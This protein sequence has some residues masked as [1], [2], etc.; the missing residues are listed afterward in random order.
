MAEVKGLWEIADKVQQDAGG[1]LMPLK[2]KI[3]DGGGKERKNKALGIADLVGKIETTESPFSTGIQINDTPYVGNPKTY[4]FNPS[5]YEYINNPQ[6][7][8]ADILGSTSAYL[9][10]GWDKFKRGG[11]QF[12]ANFLSAMGQG[13]ANLFDII[14]TKDKLGA[15]LGVNDTD[16]NS[17]FLG[18]F[19]SKD[20]MEWAEGVAERN[21][22]YQER[23]GA[24]DLT[25]GGWWANQFAQLG[26]SVGMMAFSML[27]TA[28]I[29]L[30]TG[31]TGTGVAMARL[32]R[33]IKNLFTAAKD[34]KKVSKVL[35]AAKGM[36]SA[37]TVFGIT[38]RL[39]E[40]SME[41]LQVYNKLYK[42]L[43][44]YRDEDGVGLTEEEIKHAA[45][46]GAAVDYR[47]NLAL[48]PLDILAFR[49]LVFNPISGSA[50]GWV[51]RGLKDIAGVF[52]K[53]RLGKATGWLTTKTIGINIEGIEEGFQQIGQTEGEYF[54]KR[55]VNATKEKDFYD[56]VTETVKSDEFWNNYAGGVF[57]GMFLGPLSTSVRAAV[58]IKQRRQ[59]NAAYKGYV[60]TAGTLHSEYLNEINKA[61]KEGDIVKAQQLRRQA[62]VQDFV[63]RRHL[64]NRLERT[65][66]FNSKLTFLEGVLEELNNGKTTALEDMGFFGINEKTTPEQL[67][68]I[69]ENFKTYIEDGKEVAQIYDNLKTT[70]DRAF[71]PDV[72]LANFFLKK[73]P[74]QK[75]EILAKL[76]E[77]RNNLTHYSGLSERGKRIHDIG[78][79][80]KSLQ[81]SHKRLLEILE[82]T[83][84]KKQKE[85]VRTVI[86]ANEKKID[87]QNTL[88]KSIQEDEGYD[89]ATKEA[90]N[91]I[92]TIINNN[93]NKD[94]LQTVYDKV[95]LEDQTSLATKNLTLW[96][97]EEYLNRRRE[98]AI[99]K[100]KDKEEVE[101][102]QENKGKRPETLISKVKNKANSLKKQSSTEASL[103]AQAEAKVKELDAQAGKTA[104]S[105]LAEKARLAR[106]S[107][108]SVEEADSSI[109]AILKEVNT[110]TPGNSTFN[111][112]NGEGLNLDSIPNPDELLSPELSDGEN[113]SESRESKII[114]EVGKLLNILGEDA[115]Y[116]ELLREFYK[117][118][119]IDNSEE[120]ARVLA[121]GY[122]GNKKQLSKEAEENAIS[123]VL[124]GYIT[125]LYTANS[126]I[127]EGTSS[128]KKAVQLQGAD[129]TG[130]SATSTHLGIPPMET[131]EGKVTFVYSGP[132]THEHLPKGAFSTRAVVRT[133]IEGEDNTIILETEYANEVGDSNNEFINSDILLDPDKTDSG[134]LTEIRI[135]ENVDNVTVSIYGEDG[136]FLTAMPFG[137]WVGKRAGE[138]GITIENFKNTQEYADKVP[139]IHYLKDGG[140]NGK[141]IM[142]VADIGWYHPERFDQNR[143]EERQLAIENTRR[144]RKEVI[145]SA[146][147]KVD[148]MIISKR[149]TTF[150]P[151]ILSKDAPLITLQEANPQTILAVYKEG[152]G[153]ESAPNIPAI[154]PEEGTIIGRK[155]VPIKNGAIVELRR[156]G[157]KDGKP[158]FVVLP[159]TREKI[160]TTA[161]KSVY[162]AIDIF[163]N[164]NPNNAAHV[165]AVNHIKT[166]MGLDITRIEGLSGYLKHFIHIALDDRGTKKEDVAEIMK[167]KLVHGTPY[168]AIAGGSVV[169]GRVGIPIY[170]TTDSSGKSV[171]VE[172]IF[173]TPSPKNGAVNTRARRFLT[174]S[175]S[176][177]APDENNNL[178][179]ITYKTI[180][181]WFEPSMEL[182]TYAKNKPVV[183]ITELSGFTTTQVAGSLREYLLSKLLTNVKS[184]NIGTEDAPNY[185]TNA[186][187]IVLYD[188]LSH[189]NKT[190][191]QSDVNTQQKTETEETAA[192]KNEVV[193]LTEEEKNL[194][195]E[196]EEH[197]GEDL[198]KY[199]DDG[200]YSPEILSD[201]Q[202]RYISNN[203]LG[204]IGGLDPDEAEVIINL[205]YQNILIREDFTQKGNKETITREVKEKVLSTINA[206]LEKDTA[207]LEKIKLLQDKLNSV[208]EKYDKITKVLHTLEHRI[209]KLNSIK[210]N[211][212]MFQTRALERAEKSI[213]VTLDNTEITIDDIDTIESI[214][215]NDGEVATDFFTDSLTESPEKRV[216]QEMRKLFSGIYAY[217]KNGN[218]VT[219]LGIEEFVNEEDILR[220]V[221]RLLAN[222]ESSFEV[223]INELKKYTEKYSWMQAIIN[224][225][226]Q[227][228][229]SQKLKN[230]FLAATSYNSLSM[231]HSILSYNHKTKKWTSRV[232]DSVANSTAIQI[233]RSWENNLFEDSDYKMFFV[234]EDGEQYVNKALVNRLIHVFD[235][236]TGK[237]I[238][239]LML[240]MNMHKRLVSNLREGDLAAFTPPNNVVK[241]ELEKMLTEATQEVQFGISGRQYII[242][243]EPYG[244]TVRLKG[245][246]NN[247][248][249][250]EEVKAWLKE[251]GIEVED[252]TIETLLTDGLFHGN[253]IV[254]PEGLT[255]KY[256]ILGIL[257]SKLKTLSGIGESEA[258]NI[259]D[260]EDLNPLRQN[261]I[262]S[263][264]TLDARYNTTEIP[265]ST[266]IKG[267]N[268]FGLIQNKFVVDREKE[269][270]K[271]HSK[272]RQELERAGFSRHS[273]WLKL[274]RSRIFRDGVFAIAHDGLDT[275]Q[276]NG[277]TTFRD[278]AGITNLPKKDREIAKLTKF[279]A[280]DRSTVQNEQGISEEEGIKL[281][282]ARMAGLTNADKDIMMDVR[283][284]V[285]SLTEEDLQG[286]MSDRLVKII[287]EQTVL[288][289]IQRMIDTTLA[290]EL[291]QNVNI[292]GYNKGVFV[293]NI[294]PEMNFLSVESGKTLAEAIQSNPQ[295]YNANIMLQDEG[296]RLKI[297]KTIRDTIKSL[298]S[299]KLN[300][301]KEIGIGEKDSK[302]GV[303][304]II[305]GAYFAGLSGNNISHED[306]LKYAAMDYE[307]NSLI[308]NANYMMMFTGD[309][310]MFYK[311]GVDEVESTFFNINKRNSGTIAPMS[312]LSNTTEDEQYI[313]LFI[314]DAKVTN[315]DTVDYI[316]EL[317]GEIGAEAFSEI[318]GTDSQEVTTWKEHLDNLSRLGKLQDTLMDITTE[319]IEI[320]REMLSKGTRLQDLT[321]K[322][323][324]ILTK[325]ANPLKPRYYGQIYDPNLNVMRVVYI[326]SS[327][328][329]LIPQFT[330]GKEI[331][332]LRVKMEEIEKR[333]GKNVRASH[334][335]ANKVGSVT[336]AARIW[337]EDGSIDDAEL[338][339]L[340]GTALHLYR[341]NY[342]IQ[343]EIPFKS[344]KQGQD[345]IR[346]ATQLMK[347]LF[348]DGVLDMDGF[349]LN[350]TSHTGKSLYEEY[351][352]AFIS[353]IKNKKQQLYTE[354]GMDTSGV[355]LDRKETT[356]KL[357]ALLKREAI[358]RKYPIQDIKGLRLTKQGEFIIPLWGSTNSDRYE[359]LLNS[360]VSNRI[361][362]LE[363]PGTGAVTASSVGMIEIKDFA[364]LTTEEKSQIIY[365]KA[366]DGK[367]LHGVMR[368]DGTVEFAQVFMAS[369]VKDN[370]GR[371]VDLLATDK[372]GKYIYVKETERGFELNEDMFGP[373]LLSYLSFRI[374]TSG[375]Q[376]GSRIEIAG[377]IPHTMGDI[378]FVP[379][380]FT[381]QKGLDFDA[382]KEYSYIPW[383]IQTREGKFE[384]LSDNH[385]TQFLSGYDE[386]VQKELNL[387]NKA[388]REYNM[389]AATDELA[390]RILMEEIQ[391]RTA[392]LGIV[393]VALE[394][395]EFTI[396]EIDEKSRLKRGAAKFEEKLLQNKII[397]ISKAVFSNKS[398]EMQKK[399]N[400]SLNTDFMEKQ[401]K[402]I[403]DLKGANS[404]KR[405]WSPLSSTYQGEL[406]DIGAAGKTGTGAF[407]LDVVFHS[408]LQAVKATSDVPI[409]ITM[410]IYDENGKL[411]AI[412]DKVFSFGDISSNVNLGE[413]MDATNTVSIA[414]ALTEIQQVAIDNAS[415]NLMGKLNINPETM[416]A[417]KT[418]LLT[419]V[420]KDEKGRSLPVLLLNQP[421]ILEYVRRLDNS[422]SMFEEYGENDRNSILNKL[423]EEYAEGMSEEEIQQLTE[424]TTTLL[425][426]DSLEKAI[427]DNGANKAVQLAAI[428]RYEE[429]R[430]YG[431][432][433]RSIQ[434][435]LN[436]KNSK[437]GPSFFDV[438]AKK[439]IVEKILGGSAYLQGVEKLIGNVVPQSEAEETDVSGMIRIGEYFVEPTTVVGAFVT[440]AV[441]TAYNLW[442]EYFPYDTPAAKALFAKF[443]HSIGV[444]PD[445]IGDFA[446]TRYKQEFFRSI[447][448]FMATAPEA[449]VMASYDDVNSERYRLYMD[450]PT[451]TSLPM[452]LKK[453]K[454]MRDN[455]VVKKF[456]LSN[457]FLNALT[458]ETAQNGR[459]LLKY[460]NATVDKI[461]QE[462]LYRGLS[463]MLGMNGKHGVVEL[464]AIGNKQY[465]L[466]TLAQDMIAYS[467]LGNAT[468]EAIQYTK[469]INI[470]YLNVIGY[471]KWLRN[472]ITGA[473]LATS[474]EESGNIPDVIVQ[475]IQHNPSIVKNRLPEAWAK[476]I[477]TPEYNGTTTLSNLVSFTL[478]DDFKP[479]FM[480]AYNK[481]I[482]NEKDKY[483]LYVLTDG[484][485]RRIPALGTFGMDEYQYGTQIG[486]TIINTVD[487]QTFEIL[488]TIHTSQERY[489]TGLF[490]AEAENSTLHTIVE[491]IAKANIGDISALAK[492]I[493]PYIGETTVEI[494]NEIPGRGKYSSTTDKISLNENIL[495]QKSPEIVARVIMEEVVHSLTRKQIEGYIILKA[496]GEIVVK[497]KAPDYVSDIVRLYNNIRKIV[498]KE[499]IAV[500]SAKMRNK[501]PL[502]VEEFNTIY[503]L[504]DIYEFMAQAI[505]NKEFLKFLEQDK[506]N[507]QNGKTVL[508]RLKDIVVKVFK[509]IGINLKADSAAF[510]A[511]NSIFELIEEENKENKEN[512]I[513]KQSLELQKKIQEAKGAN[514]NQSKGFSSDDPNNVGPVEA[515][516]SPNLT[517]FPIDNFPEIP[518]NIKTQ[519]CV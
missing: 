68:I 357:Q 468:Q 390:K 147:A 30:L 460:D 466:D 504:T 502:T 29:E 491:N 61:E 57:G 283:T 19:S 257:Y 451:N 243:K 245:A 454:A 336:N 380:E 444:N 205:I 364:N 325:V 333:T 15:A 187:P 449:G 418:M 387:L 236:W 64:D 72:V 429:L 144:I 34:T 343:Q 32:G 500:V 467:L 69:K 297:Y 413:S 433:I 88:L 394:E 109:E 131:E 290:I 38:N 238:P 44:E 510:Q 369:K 161:R 157:T 270:R 70:Y 327:S 337:K 114:T 291:G 137:V 48:L 164:F 403:N 95:S 375:H 148:A 181:H 519:M 195:N 311:A 345:T 421:I 450:T 108:F 309:P 455:P 67:E 210:D 7:A 107:K 353:L 92:L 201:S 378:M 235:V 488:P 275:L 247:R 221:M 141:G 288:P 105:R 9:Q 36:K 386:T 22:I 490:G 138:L 329:P 362:A 120:L 319:E 83:E 217:D 28:G 112:E 37:A 119:G 298:T 473:M 167:G 489:S 249:K 207:Y 417:L 115:T 51:E 485:Y 406:M 407:S 153:Y 96:D 470:S 86:T 301:W 273:L 87:A 271:E 200:N 379:S 440:E 482:K 439:E 152:I 24:F 219:T 501:E 193:N 214:N 498:G 367:G 368:K 341:K 222:T 41:G 318:N 155:D 11:K 496:D 168:I 50:T 472:N 49:L 296:I 182:H 312:P 332:K 376:S 432:K 494:D 428:L 315:L 117:R 252:R 23:E 442:G 358:S 396:K 276:K 405:L 317:Q 514:N 10:P 194:L 272:V 465:T 289:E 517:I 293:F 242:R 356:R 446:R 203:E 77:L 314:E 415:L 388:I 342:G 47:W 479:P 393:K 435:G 192:E 326:K 91:D 410:P 499:A 162:G 452:Y 21:R 191:T 447:K 110:S 58:N 130:T 331:D 82:E 285:L 292:S 481:S 371:L 229:L 330:R 426:G 268:I 384:I 478:L 412:E 400:K 445:E 354:L 372:D 443:F 151:F 344:H 127:G 73:V 226:E 85:N 322:Q 166:T 313:Q 101:E 264:A 310:A 75:T 274:L 516:F 427:M 76:T 456:I 2:E 81:Y 93:P 382:D 135:P 424:N 503:G 223:K 409:K 136:A 512:F 355:P 89:A 123:K 401:A 202:R 59:M 248:L 299:E 220:T 113:L 351:T 71:L 31:G 471:S 239:R 140:N 389:L 16:F 349:M 230:K 436:F 160:D 240:N 286:E 45:S 267:K 55:E 423:F 334:Q 184:Y 199:G 486:S 94:Y 225:L 125:K 196:I 459:S 462:T 391:E 100:A 425:R 308:A 4:N 163:A 106:E 399:I 474:T 237:S 231:W 411:I 132:V 78:Y 126:G 172:S 156:F 284:A 170:T 487:R 416:D 419:G 213:G 256:G 176:V 359:A 150:A 483:Q 493:L 97:D 244:Y 175:F 339:K 159:V 484:V 374:P 360:I 346:L 5:D 437:F 103:A 280:N 154:K 232:V 165:S 414:D 398:N 145:E 277:K 134:T 158:T 3:N 54:G 185:V 42:D 385:K 171:G 361:L 335:S 515:S 143:E 254:K 408:L 305:D 347:L 74:E 508:E 507:L 216:S 116:E 14:E 186:Q 365:T 208:E 324:E 228:N 26:T 307:I 253:K 246:S 43:K 84:D 302:T 179:N 124:D 251:F 262:Y 348:G 303:A 448:K 511:F 377:F 146:E 469:Y 35:E 178:K 306:R 316:R 497:E 340:E 62:N 476:S 218:I 392:I 294:I 56:R 338:D 300:Y 492:E 480:V 174:N 149:Q 495:S 234:G 430:D 259:E 431:L 17:T 177:N 20:L 518:L 227:T 261:V 40:S 60:K 142:Y 111:V 422:F 128:Q 204:E 8:D 6:V 133:R 397:A 458:T 173:L 269:L 370:S 402:Y 278:K 224:R 33:S 79:E 255:G 321:K 139:M 381:T 206:T 80:I 1:P 475:Y 441:S 263:L 453:L 265:F 505:K 363:F 304:N 180:L 98:R 129:A 350:G 121:F 13:V 420:V 90:D 215:D 188:T 260:R 118:V 477:T 438:V 287:Y 27:E 323:Q 464:P 25:D 366:W 63:Y 189:I 183:A 513:S 122:R 209:Y 39:N 104:A 12:S 46:V 212:K 198:G 233:R 266:R 395:T 53:S 373:E 99:K 279:W 457:P 52:G 328:Y 506:F 211:Y 66:A 102:I 463:A 258:V 282:V 250:A 461:N 509:S 169:M 241:E 65:G 295:K 197:L 190:V 281:R 352:N 18:L 320:A 383:H 434:T 404:K